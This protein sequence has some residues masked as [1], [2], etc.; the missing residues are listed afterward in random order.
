VGYIN[1]FGITYPNGPDLEMKI[2]QAF[3][4]TGVPETYVIDQSGKLA[5][6]KIGV[7]NN[8]NEIKSAIDPL[9]TP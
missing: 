9:L 7:F 4:M 8:L 3:R 5:Y 2:S 6:K 1:K